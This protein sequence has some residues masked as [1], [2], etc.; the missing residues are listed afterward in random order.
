MLRLSAF[1]VALFSLASA[2]L[3]PRA[4]GVNDFSCKSASQPV[5]VVL[6]HGLGATFYEDLNVLQAY[7]ASKDFCTF[8][9][10]Y[11]DYDGFP[12]V[13]GLKPLNESSEQLAQ[14]IAEVTSKTGASKVDI[15]GHSEGGLLVRSRRS[16]R[17]S[18][19]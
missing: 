13:G 12:F 11:G 7:L 19:C 16:R 14:Y 10:T 2:A 17:T 15:V 1:V 6:F 9:I 5:P 4:A 8:A 18:S 3:L